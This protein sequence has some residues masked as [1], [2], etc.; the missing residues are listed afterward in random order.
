MK[1]ILILTAGFG[2]GHNAAARGL[3]DALA[4][5]GEA[6][7]EYHDLFA[8]TY[9]I[10]NEWTRKFYLGLINRYPHRWST[11]YQWLDR[12][13]DFAGNFRFLFA[14]KNRLSQLLA[15]FRPDAIVSV[16]PVY[17]HLL[18]EVLGPSSGRDAKRISIVTDS[19]TVNAIWYRCTA[20]FFLV[21]NEPTANV[22]RSVGVPS[23]KIRDFG[24]PVSPKFAQPGV[25]QPSA[26]AP[27]R[28]ILYMINAGK[29]IA[30]DLVRRLCAIDQT[31]LTVTVGRD[32]QLRQ[33]IE[34]VQRAAGKAFEIVGWSEEMPRFMRES[35]LLVGKAGGATVQETIAAGCPMIINHVVPGQEEGN[36]RLIQQTNS[37]MVAQS[38]EAVVAA[39]EQA[40]ANDAAVWRQWTGNIRALSRP[41][42]ALETA[43]FILSL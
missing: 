5:I 30:P 26:D 41:S 32:L 10:A 13:S 40:F 43:R 38:H 24:F 27:E 16:Y 28:R 4:E 20:D 25:N 22:L 39:I 21:P 23:E 8:E 42:A 3:R 33:A 37:G 18:D 19:I 9:G 31:H 29:T 15:R 11:F 1:R 36:A 35:H 14:L 7:V 2:E 6:E 17:S 12:K 34:D